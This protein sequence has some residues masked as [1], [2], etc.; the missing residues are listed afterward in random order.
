M[1]EL[2]ISDHGIQTIK[3]SRIHSLDLI[4]PGLR[5]RRFLSSNEKLKVKFG[6]LLFVIV[7][8]AWTYNHYFV[9]EYERST[10]AVMPFVNATGN[11]KLDYVAAGLR[12]EISGSLSQISSMDVISNSSI[13]ATS[14]QN[15]SFGQITEELDLDHLVIGKISKK[16]SIIE[17]SVRLFEKREANNKIIFSKTG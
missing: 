11:P 10:V 13:S 4:L 6:I 17:L 3:N 7:I 1:P 2:S 14:L 15:L 5:K 16:R 9:T 8:S 12:N